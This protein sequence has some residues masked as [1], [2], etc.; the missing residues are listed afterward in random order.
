VVSDA[1]CAHPL[2][3]EDVQTTPSGRQ[4]IEADSEFLLDA[5]SP[6]RTTDET[7]DDARRRIR[8]AAG[9]RQRVE[10][11]FDTAVIEQVLA[12][13]ANAASAPLPGRYRIVG[14]DG[15]GELVVAIPFGTHP[16][17]GAPDRLASILDEDLGA[18]AAVGTWALA[19][20]DQPVRGA[21]PAVVRSWSADQR[22]LVPVN[23][24]DHVAIDR[25][26]GQSVVVVRS[27][28]LPQ[29]TMTLLDRADLVALV[30]RLLV[31]GWRILGLD[32]AMTL[33]TQPFAPKK[34][35]IAPGKDVSR[36]PQLGPGRLRSHRKLLAREIIDLDVTQP[37]LPQLPTGRVAD[38]IGIHARFGDTRFV[39]PSIPTGGGTV[40][41]PVLIDLL[42]E[43][44]VAAETSAAPQVVAG[45]PVEIRVFGEQTDGRVARSTIEARAVE[46]FGT[47]VRVIDVDAN[48][49]P[50]KSEGDQPRRQTPSPDGSHVTIALD[51]G[52][53]P[54]V[55][56]LQTAVDEARRHG[57]ASVGQLCPRRITTEPG[58]LYSSVLDALAC[59]SRS[60]TGQRTDGDSRILSRTMARI[61]ARAGFAVVTE[62][63]EGICQARTMDDAVATLDT[64]QIRFGPIP[65]VVTEKKTNADVFRWLG[66]IGQASKGGG[67]RLR[68]ASLRTR[69]RIVR[70][71]VRSAQVAGTAA[72]ARATVSLLRPSHKRRIRPLRRRLHT[73]PKRIVTVGAR[74]QHHATASGYERSF[75][76]FARPLPTVSWRWLAGR[77]TNVER[78]LRF[79]SDNPTYST[80]ALLSE[81]RAIPSMV[82]RPWVQHHQIYGETDGWLLPILGRWRPYSA[83]LHM[84]PWRF[85]ELGVGIDR[86]RNARVLVV[87][88]PSLE[89]YVRAGIPDATVQLVEIGVD[90]SRFRD[91]IASEEVNGALIGKL[92]FVLCVGGHLRDFDTLARAWLQARSRFTGPMQLKIIGAPPEIRD[93]MNGLGCPDLEALIPIS[94]DELVDAY[95]KCRAATIPLDGATANTALL[96]ARA[97]G[98]PVFTT[99]SI[100]TRHYLGD[101]GATY[102]PRSDVAAWTACFISLSA[103]DPPAATDDT[104]GRFRFD[105]VGARLQ[106]ALRC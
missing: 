15:P 58:Y 54:S 3:V 18:A 101:G 52:S 86:F 91:G 12:E 97:A 100:G 76:S 35:I 103:G 95:R 40:S 38:E 20:L 89:A 8:S 51:R 37:W 48:A 7:F 61:A 2:R 79:V 69:S 105:L 88:D 72:S 96:E 57:R 55:A 56:W 16:L 5:C 10:P 81:I 27:A 74:Y 60:G 94:D 21:R 102:F 64:S 68:S 25:L 32:A 104:V 47:S 65:L 34:G 80:G 36:A 17:P 33:S 26:L 98:A 90:D 23:I 50:A 92:P 43:A 4:A 39:L 46:A 87:V 42:A 24:L 66:E 70:T 45:G 62:T 75:E 41:I 1:N 73:Q 78:L 63:A 53:D 93:Y 77:W 6:D 9:L 85:A 19:G 67:L 83:S 30:D 28:L 29:A 44:L 59:L 84:P 31:L 22:G 14:S 82:A 71:I 106:V 13:N 11:R 49:L 99:D